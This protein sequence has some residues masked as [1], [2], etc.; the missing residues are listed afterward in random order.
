MPQS[1]T[2]HYCGA[3]K[4]DGVHACTNPSPMEFVSGT[5]NTSCSHDHKTKQVTWKWIYFA[6][7]QIVGLSF[8]NAGLRGTSVTFGTINIADGNYAEIRTPII[9]TLT[10]AMHNYTSTCLD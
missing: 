3:K 7:I 1:N 5:L 6:R 10:S 8:I 9:R 2:P 4:Q